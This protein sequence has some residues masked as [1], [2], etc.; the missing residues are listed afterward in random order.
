MSHQLRDLVKRVQSGDIISRYGGM[1]KDNCDQLLAEDQ[2]S[3]SGKLKRH[4]SG[5]WAIAAPDV[6]IIT[7]FLGKVIRCLLRP[8]LAQLWRLYPRDWL[9]RGLGCETTWA[10][11]Y[12]AWHSSKAMRQE[13]KNEY[14]RACDSTLARGLDLDLIITIR[15]VYINSYLIMASWRVQLVV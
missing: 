1:P 11:E 6:H 15:T 7:S 9:W 5:S 8:V 14:D 2:Q 4:N 3:T 13:L 12:F 10:E